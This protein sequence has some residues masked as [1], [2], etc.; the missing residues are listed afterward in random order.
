MERHH[1]RAIP[2]GNDFQSISIHFLH[3]LLLHLSLSLSLISV[4]L[5]L[6][7]QLATC[8]LPLT[9]S[10][11]FRF[12]FGNISMAISTFFL[13][14]YLAFL[15]CVFHLFWFV[16]FLWF[17]GA[18]A[19][20]GP[21]PVSL[22]AGVFLLFFGVFFLFFFVLFT[23]FLLRFC[24]GIVLVFHGNPKLKYDVTPPGVVGFLERNPFRWV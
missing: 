1:R 8:R 12:V 23:F 4:S 16:F 14:W 7:S 10:P 6:F 15:M 18:E 3:P 11:I 13:V 2:H 24:G 20:R 9:G 17:Y 21:A 5:Y 19:R 22:S